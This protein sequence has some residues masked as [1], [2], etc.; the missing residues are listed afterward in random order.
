[1][2]HSGRIYAEIRILK[3][4]E[5]A[6]NRP[7]MFNGKMYDGEHMHLQLKRKRLQ[8]LGQLPELGDSSELKMFLTYEGTLSDTR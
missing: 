2:R 5:K 7:F 4:L 8:L 1:M 6:L 3:S